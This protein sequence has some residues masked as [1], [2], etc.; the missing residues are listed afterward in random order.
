MKILAF[1]VLASMAYALDH[2]PSMAEA[3]KLVCW[4]IAG[5]VSLGLTALGDRKA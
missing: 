4:L 5:I 3:E 1:L 2:S